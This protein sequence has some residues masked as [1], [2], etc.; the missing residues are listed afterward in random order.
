MVGSA[1]GLEGRSCHGCHSLLQ[2]LEDVV[3]VIV[4]EDGTQGWVLIHL[5]LAQQ[6]QLQVAQDFAYTERWGHL[7]QRCLIQMTRPLGPANQFLTTAPC[8]SDP[9]VS[10]DRLNP[11][12]PN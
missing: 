12:N 11:W 6:V 5:R 8:S 9:Q 4:Q 7:Y 2:G 3:V 1:P 10:E